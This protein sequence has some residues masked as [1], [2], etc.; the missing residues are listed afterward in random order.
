M[1]SP[2]TGG[3]FLVHQEVMC[4]FPDGPQP[5]LLC[6]LDV[7]RPAGKTVCV[8]LDCSDSY[9]HAMQDLNRLRR[10]IAAWPSEWQIEFYQ[11]SHAECLFVES[12]S[13]FCGV[14][15]RAERHYE[16][17]A[18]PVPAQYR[19]SFLRP[20]IEAMSKRRSMDPVSVERIVLVLGDGHFTDFMLPA[21]PDWME[22]VV[23]SDRPSTERVLNAQA[24]PWGTVASCQFFNIHKAKFTGE[25]PVVIDGAPDS[26]RCYTL[27]SDRLLQWSQPTETLV[28]LQNGAAIFLV[29]CKPEQ[30]LELRWA[31]RLSGVTV[32][33]PTSK[34][35]SIP[36]L[37]SLQPI[38]STWLNDV[39]DDRSFEILFESSTGTDNYIEALSLFESAEI[40][41]REH[42]RWNQSSVPKDFDRLI[43]S[44]DNPS[45]TRPIDAVLIAAARTGQDAIPV[46]LIALGLIR[47]LPVLFHC[48]DLI[49]SFVVQAP[50]SISF[51]S[52]RRRWIVQV[53]TEE[54][55]ELGI[56]SQIVKL[57]VAYPPFEVVI[58]FAKHSFQ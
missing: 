42:S 47:S 6:R 3:V 31:I 46:E 29:D 32:S 30:T 8:V 25:I 37:P 40:A 55:E 19:G 57:P 22:F 45:L 10:V 14:E 56:S 34:A 4:E 5:R 52:E 48:G 11:L 13:D 18:N 27:T 23:A 24:L 44:T 7:A 36:E 21:V 43:R 2:D 35:S 17:N 38:I 39:G 50:F 9:G 20:C 12:I 58:Q 26:A 16:S 28:N 53:G 41:A 15:R 1:T 49:G 54:P 33:L 51:S